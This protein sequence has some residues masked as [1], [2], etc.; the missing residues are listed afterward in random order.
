M[1]HYLKIKIVNRARYRILESAERAVLVAAVGAVRA[2][3]AL[4]PVPDA[5][6]GGVAG[7]P[8]LHLLAV[9]PARLHRLVAAVVAIP[10]SVAAEV[11]PPSDALAAVTSELTRA[12]EICY[13]V[14]NAKGPCTVGSDENFQI[15]C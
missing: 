2:P 9:T 15:T 7:E 4:H 8:P 10:V 12:A 3:V 11:L 6:A 1:T 5:L 14:L 13:D